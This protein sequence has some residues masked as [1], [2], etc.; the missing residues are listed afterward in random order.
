MEFKLNGKKL[1]EVLSKVLPAVPS[2]TTNQALLNFLFEIKD[3]ILK[4]SA[5]DGELTISATMDVLA[6]ENI[7]FGLP[8]KL[9]YDTVKN[10]GDIELKIVTEDSQKIKIYANRGVYT[11][12]YFDEKDYPVIPKFIEEYFTEINGTDLKALIEKTSFA[13][14]DANDARVAM[15]GVL[16]DFRNN[17]LTLVA[18]DGHTLVRYSRTNVVADFV[19]SYVVPERATSALTKVLEDKPVKMFLSSSSIMFKTAGYEVTTRLINQKYPDYNAVIPLETSKTLKLKCEDL[20]VVLKRMLIYA[21]SQT[22]KVKFNVSSSKLKISADDPDFSAQ[23]IEDIDCEFNGDEM[24]IGFNAQFFNEI[25]SHLPN[26]EV[27]MKMNTP[28]KAVIL[29]PTE[30]I[31]NEELLVL[32][33]PV[34]LNA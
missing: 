12:S 23:A 20:R 6:G 18:T 4:V 5:T 22:K 1:E 27:V 25:L 16:F 8:A 28:Q 19:N 24:E 17:G 26:G 9:L 13:A 3:G 32:L 14:S 7:S 2:R 30:N 15:T 31:E 21:T 34:R 10:L 33:M 11:L 29:E